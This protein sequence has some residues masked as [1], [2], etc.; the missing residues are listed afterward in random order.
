MKIALI[1]DIHGNLPAFKAVL[2]DMPSVDSI[3]CCG[4]FSEYYPD[5]NDVC[6]LVQDNDI[7]T[8]R[9]NHDAYVLEEIMPDPDKVGLYRTEWTRDI[10]HKDN[11][12]WLLSLPVELGFQWNEIRMNVRHANPWDEMLYL[13]ADSTEFERF[14][15]NEADIWV[16]GHTHHPFKKKLNKTMIVNP[17]SVG[18]PR[19]W[20]PQS[21]Y[22][23]MDVLNKTVEFKRVPYNVEQYQKKLKEMDWPEQLISILSRSRN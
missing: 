11:K 12:K 14:P 4:D 18:Q 6:K 1:A 2:N 8:V 15:E 7:I 20:N 3:V 9:G 21:S 22:A 17:G 10:I 23:I 19:D 5:V 16:F 13:Y